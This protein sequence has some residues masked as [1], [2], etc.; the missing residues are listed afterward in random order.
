MQELQFDCALP[1]V[2]FDA[3]RKQAVMLQE[4]FVVIREATEVV[5][6]H[7]ER[8]LPSDGREQLCASVRDCMQEVEMWS[9]STPTM[10]ELDR[11]VKRV[12][13]LHIEVTKLERRALVAKG[14]TPTP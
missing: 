7:L 12:L 3:E 8:L 9:V 1:I 13:A 6:R 5:L 11:L 14:D 10:G 2:H 4:R